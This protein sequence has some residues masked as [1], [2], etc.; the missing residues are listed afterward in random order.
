MTSDEQLAKWLK[1]NSIHNDTRGECCPDFSCCT[2]ELLADE[3]V[4]KA[5][6]NADEGTRMSMLG[7]FLGAAFAKMGKDKKVYIA[8]L[9]ESSIEH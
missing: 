2:P 7:M 5:F 6:V 4:R 1:G 9:D 3:D 8:G